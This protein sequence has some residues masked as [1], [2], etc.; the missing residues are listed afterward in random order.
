MFSLPCTDLFAA[1][2]GDERAIAPG[3][4]PTP[5]GVVSIRLGRRDVYR[6][7]GS[8]SA[9]QRSRPQASRVPA[10]STRANATTGTPRCCAV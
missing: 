8:A 10:A 2:Y 3:Q 7:P 5:G 1:V 6:L 9:P 4:P